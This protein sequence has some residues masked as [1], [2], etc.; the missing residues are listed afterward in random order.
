MGIKKRTRP[1][2]DDKLEKLTLFTERSLGTRKGRIEDHF[3]R[4]PMGYEP[5]P[6]TKVDAT[7]PFIDWELG[8]FVMAALAKTRTP[9]KPA[10]DR[11]VQL[12]ESPRPTTC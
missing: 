2:A 8:W 3:R 9:I 10:W 6:I 11:F 7:D 12:A 4:G 5:F 1:S